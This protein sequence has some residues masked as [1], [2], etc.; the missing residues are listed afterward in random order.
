LFETDLE[1]MIVNPLPAN[2]ENMVRSE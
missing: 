2:L 1:E